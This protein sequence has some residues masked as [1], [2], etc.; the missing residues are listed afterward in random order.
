MPVEAEQMRSRVAEAPNGYLATSGRDGRPHIVPF[1]FVL[2]GDA[3][4]SAV[5]A[6]PKRSV[7]LQRLENVRRQPLVSVLVD[8]YA[9][10]W[11]QLWWVRLDGRGEVLPEGAESDHALELLAGKYPQYRAVPPPG[12]VLKVA[13]ER[14]RGWS[15]R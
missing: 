10:D 8:H 3:I 12:P 9:E 1:C 5:D 4:Y 15:A 11:E 13:V 7:H 14:W 6:K 2:V